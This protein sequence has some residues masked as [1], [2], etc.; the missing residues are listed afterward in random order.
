MSPFF[1]AL[2]EGA[3]R[4]R[5][6]FFVQVD[7]DMILD[8]GC[9]QALRSA[10]R[11]DTGVVVGELRDA[12]VGNVVGVKLFRTECFRRVGFADSISADT[13][14]VTGLARRGWATV[15]I[16]SSGTVGEHR[17]HY[18]PAYTY[19]KH[20]IEG[21]RY[22]Y[23]SAPWGLKSRLAALEASHHPLAPLAQ[24]ALGHGFFWRSDADELKPPSAEPQAEWLHGLLGSGVR[25][26]ETVAGLVPF[27]RRGLLGDVHRR[28]LGA[29]RALAEAHAGGTV[30]SVLS[31]LAG[32][33]TDRHVLVAK[34]ALA[35][36]L[37]E[38]SLDP[39]REAEDEELLR[40]F[41]MLGLGRKPG[42]TRTAAAR[43]RQATR[44]FRRNSEARW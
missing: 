44:A 33:A 40:R 13:E 43:V 39:V 29:G 36:G 27:R 18:T 15:Y 41:V 23:R 35:H 42:V 11:S 8:P 2:N 34:V 21:R 37:L 9:V 19:R 12:L 32:A 6:E 10:V 31:G 26:D 5:T 30:L 25:Q 22:W 28:F 3:G 20:L 16:S 17:P 24:V 14:F 1:R 38:E 4:V 7:E